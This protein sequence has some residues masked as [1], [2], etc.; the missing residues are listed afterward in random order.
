MS[1]INHPKHY[2]SH[3]IVCECGKTLECLDIVKELPFT[4]GNIIKYIWRWRDKN[5]LED[6]LKAQFYLNDL[7]KNQ[8]IKKSKNN[9]LTIDDLELVT[10]AEHCLLAEGLDTVEKIINYPLK[11]Q[12]PKALQRIPNFGKKSYDNLREQLLKHNILIRE[13]QS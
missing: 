1:N 7:I 2:Q 4:E 6:L 8:K 11:T 13:W 5:G 12:D 9:S 3:N 10:R